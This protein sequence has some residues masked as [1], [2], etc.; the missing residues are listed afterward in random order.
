MGER[1]ICIGDTFMWQI[2]GRY[3]GRRVVP[4]AR[5]M[6]LIAA[7]LNHVTQ[8]T[9]IRMTM[10]QSPSTDSPWIISV[11][12]EWLNS[13]IESSSPSGNFVTLDTQ[14]NI[15]ANKNIVGSVLTVKYADG[16]RYAEIGSGRISLLASGTYPRPYIDFH[17]NGSSDYTARIIAQSS[18]ELR[19]SSGSLSLYTQG[20]NDH[21][22]LHS[23]SIYFYY[24]NSDSDGATSR[25]TAA[26]ANE[27]RVSSNIFSIWKVGENDRVEIGNDSIKLKDGSS[28]TRAEVLQSAFTINDGSGVSRVMLF[29]NSGLGGI[30]ISNASGS[31]IG[32]FDVHES[33]YGTYGLLQCDGSMNISSGSVT[34]HRESSGYALLNLHPI[35]T[36]D[37]LVD[38][39]A[40]RQIATVGY[41]NEKAGGVPESPSSYTALTTSGEGSAAAKSDSWTYDGTNGVKV[42]VQTR[43]YYDHTASTPVL[44]GYYRTFTYDKQ[45]RLYSV[46]AETRYVIDQPVVANLTATA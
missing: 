21:I 26:S 5:Q 1:D 27:L 6:N 28:V 18:T 14:Q 31:T 35:A 38:T 32:A 41:V 23:N 16:S 22:K 40:A 11:D 36:T 45:G 7:I 17:Y 44:Y 3:K 9:G 43:T 42:T 29:Y 20:Q 39:A 24:G 8:G 10:P 25:I 13:I 4:T 19:I 2:F 33:A 12:E 15:T 34:I 46:S 30:L 37:K